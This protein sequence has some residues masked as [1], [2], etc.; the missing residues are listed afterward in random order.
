MSKWPLE[1]FPPVDRDWLAEN[2]S[3]FTVPARIAKVL[4]ERDNRHKRHREELLQQQREELL[5]LQREKA[6]KQ[7]EQREESDEDTSGDC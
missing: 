5:R 2:A 6:L 3:A 7:E 1:H 4:A